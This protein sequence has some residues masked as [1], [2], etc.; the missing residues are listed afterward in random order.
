L[1]WGGMEW[2]TLTQNRVR[3]WAVVNAVMNLLAP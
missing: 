3:C 2:I 1:G